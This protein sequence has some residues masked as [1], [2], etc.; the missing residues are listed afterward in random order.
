M[1]DGQ[2]GDWVGG[3]PSAFEVFARV[4]IIHVIIGNVQYKI[5]PIVLKVIIIG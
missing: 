1:S 2:V 3:I 4:E 5:R